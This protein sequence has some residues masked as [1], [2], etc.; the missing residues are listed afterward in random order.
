L[1]CLSIYPS[2]YLF[3]SPSDILDEEMKARGQGRFIMHHNGVSYLVNNSQE[4]IDLM[5]Q[6]DENQARELTSDERRKFCAL[7]NDFVRR[8]TVY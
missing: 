2:T 7:P 3:I 8:L 4:V 1:I 5:R 6:H